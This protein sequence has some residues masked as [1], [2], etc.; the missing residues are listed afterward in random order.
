[1]GIFLRLIL[2]SISS[3]GVRFLKQMRC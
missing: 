1:M 2:K 3:H